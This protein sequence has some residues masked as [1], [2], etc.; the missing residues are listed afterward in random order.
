LVVQGGKRR[1]LQ[2]GEKEV[3]QGFLS[4]DGRKVT[5]KWRGGEGVVFD[6]EYMSSCV[7]KLEGP[8]KIGEVN[9]S[10]IKRGWWMVGYDIGNVQ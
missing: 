9:G 3:F 6:S 7:G 2:R 1:G 5:S 4:Q 10:C 8:E